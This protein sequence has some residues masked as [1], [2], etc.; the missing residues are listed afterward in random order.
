MKR[1]KLQDAIGMVDGDLVAR[2][3]EMPARR[4]LP[5]WWRSAVAAMLAVAVLIGALW[6]ISPLQG[7]YMIAEASYPIMAPY[8]D[9]EGSREDYDA[10]YA[11]VQER[12]QYYGAGAGLGD[13]LSS[14]VSTFLAGDE[15]KNRVF[16]PLNVY[17]ALAMLAEVTDGESRAEILTLLGSESIEALRTQANAVWNANY[18]D[19][20]TVTS[21]LGSSIWLDEDVAYEADTLKRLA[22][23]YY[24]SSFQGEMG[25]D[26]YN[27]ALAAWLNEHTGGL[28][29]AYADSIELPPETVMALA[30]TMYY[31]AKWNQKFLSASNK[32][33][34]FYA[35]QGELL[36][37]F[38]NQTLYHGEYYWGEHF[39]ATRKALENSGYMYLILPDEG[40]SPAALLSDSE[41]LAFMTANGDWENS[42][43]VKLNL[44]MPKFDVDASTD[45]LAGL[46]RLGIE[47]C[48][49]PATADFSPLSENNGQPIWLAGADH[50]AR[51]I[52]DEDGI[53]AAAYTVMHAD[54]A[55]AAPG[56]EIDFI[57]N[58]PFVFVITGA[59][60]LPLFVGTVYTP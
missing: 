27:K 35:P 51:V 24:A 58:R 8:P 42:S 30:T 50:A 23:I 18:C 37:D 11:S 40:V 59:D 38:M 7:G 22:E 44:S 28:L 41:A 10:W 47:A 5:R 16:S 33:D 12:R 39:S 31:R 36:C 57:L 48:L 15:P 1:D 55:P 14:T 9:E 19:D 17:M 3:G 6:N 13:F 34:R 2:A 29:S 43:A 49:D 45:L 4:Q 32:K 53:E 25:T 52:V 26:G 60:G 20:G 21:L 56:E 54:S 46:R